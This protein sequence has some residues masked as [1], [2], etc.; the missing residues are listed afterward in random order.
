MTVE[1]TE[2]VYKI[3]TELQKQSGDNIF[4]C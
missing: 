1:Q 2:K 3:L 4:G